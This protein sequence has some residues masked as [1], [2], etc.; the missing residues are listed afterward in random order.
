MERAM[1]PFVNTP[2]FVDRPGAG[3]FALMLHPG[4]MTEG[5]RD[6]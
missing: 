1:S 5:R 3:C 4:Q 6:A 2:T